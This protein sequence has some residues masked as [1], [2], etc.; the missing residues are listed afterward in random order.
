MVKIIIVSWLNEPRARAIG[1]SN[2]AD[3]YQIKPFD[4]LARVRKNVSVGSQTQLVESTRTPLEYLR[5]DH[6]SNAVA[7]QG[8]VTPLSPRQFDLLN[9]LVRAAG[10]CVTRERLC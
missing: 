6:A 1:F 8:Q 3:D 5:L 10:D 9:H 4:L 7:F 2:G